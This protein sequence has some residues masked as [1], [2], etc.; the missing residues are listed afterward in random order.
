LCCGPP[1]LRGSSRT[2]SEVRPSPGLR[3][4]TRRSLSGR[5]IRVHANQRLDPRRRVREP[6]I[7]VVLQVADP[8]IDVAALRE[9]TD[10][11]DDERHD[12]AEHWQVGEDL[13]VHS[14]SILPLMSRP[15]D[16]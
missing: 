3:R 12:R 14:T 7:H 13:L 9:Y 15:E 8:H 16:R 11:H 2:R 1:G 10:I 4:I 5:S 6:L